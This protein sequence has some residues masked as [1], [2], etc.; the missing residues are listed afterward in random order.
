MSQQK[1]RG[2]ESSLRAVPDKHRNK[3]VR[4]I[5]NNT[6]TLSR[7]TIFVR[8]PDFESFWHYDIQRKM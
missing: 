2:S 4:N 7:T 8:N 6:V 5:D 1:K 3:N